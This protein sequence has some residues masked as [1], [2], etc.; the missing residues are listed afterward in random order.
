M[1][2]YKSCNGL[3][4]T[5]TGITE[6]LALAIIFLFFTSDI[7]FGLTSGTI[8]GISGSFLKYFELSITTVFLA[9]TWAHFSATPLPAAKKA[10]LTE[11][12]LNF[13]RSV[14]VCSFP[15]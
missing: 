1:I 4:A 6:Q 11:E 5:T 14:T 9:A 10:I 15:L 7:F 3:R 13:S 12:K 2:L 8:N